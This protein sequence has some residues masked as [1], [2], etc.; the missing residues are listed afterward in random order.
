[1]CI[2]LFWW[3]LLAALFISWVKRISVEKRNVFHWKR[4][5]M[6]QN[7]LKVGTWAERSISARDGSQRFF[8]IV[9]HK[10]TF[11]NYELHFEG[12]LVTDT[13]F[14]PCLLRCKLNEKK[15]EKNSEA[16]EKIRRN[17]EK[18]L[19]QCFWKLI[20]SNRLICCKLLYR[21]FHFD[22]SSLPLFVG[23]VVAHEQQYL[24]LLYCKLLKKRKSRSQEAQDSLSCGQV[25]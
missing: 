14:Y 23:V 25:S 10:M 15:K 21:I 12:P 19:F 13:H 11:T 2:D 4:K 7:A 18:N 1:M 24:S 8:I 22:W 16:T 9:F 17:G 5:K 3:L 20:T 6:P